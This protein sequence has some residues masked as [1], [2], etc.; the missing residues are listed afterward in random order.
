MFTR[1]LLQKQPQNGLHFAKR[2]TNTAQQAQLEGN[3][4][5]FHETGQEYGSIKIKNAYINILTTK[6]ETKN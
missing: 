1:L 5:L 3:S 4:R 2:A 6:G